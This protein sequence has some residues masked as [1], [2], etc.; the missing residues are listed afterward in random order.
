M[1]DVIQA[2]IAFREAQ[3]LALFQVK[4]FFLIIP[5]CSNCKPLRALDIPEKDLFL[6]INYRIF[7]CFTV[8]KNIIYESISNNSLCM[9]V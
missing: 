6:G 7:L 3:K 9:L 8:P 5:A 2:Q 4:L 1:T